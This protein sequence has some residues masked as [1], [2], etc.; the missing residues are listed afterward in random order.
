MTRSAGTLDRLAALLVGIALIGLGAGALIWNTTLVS[1]IPELVT[2]PE[3]VDDTGTS[4]WPWAVAGAGI[5][6]IVLGGRW[7]LAHTPAAKAKALRVNGPED[8]GAI[9]VDL[10]SLATAAA[11]TLA[12]RPDVTAAKG[13]AVI[14]RGTRTLD[15]TITATSAEDL[16]GVIDAVDHTCAHLASATGDPSIATR[17][18]IHL[19]K[20]P[21]HDHH[22]V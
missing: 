16:R 3:L 11:R 14:D 7:L 2:A 17:T 20:D 10:G 8:L 1:G 9:T 5:V 15:L 18:T 22:V 12:D 19:S 6:L 4:W 21:H 13:K